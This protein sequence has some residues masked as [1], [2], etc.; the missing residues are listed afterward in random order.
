MSGLQYQSARSKLSAERESAENVRSVFIMPRMILAAFAIFVLSAMVAS[1]SVQAQTGRPVS[2]V[3]AATDKPIAISYVNEEGKTIGR[4]AGVGE[5]IYL[6]DEIVTPAGA[7]MQVL[8]RDQTVF[9]IGPDSRLVFDEFIFDPS[10]VD[11]VAMTATVKKGTF[12]FI[13]GKISKLK[14]GAMT[15]KLPNA[16]ASVRGTSVVGRVADDGASDIVLLTGAVQLATSAGAPPV[17]LIQPGWGVSI[18]DTGA[19]SEPEPFPVEEINEIIQQVE[20]AEDDEAQGTEEAAGDE[21]ASDEADGQEAE[22]QEADGQEAEGQ[23]AGADEV[24]EEETVEAIVTAVNEAGEDVSAEEIVSIIE[25]ADGNAEAVAEAIVKVIIENQIER[26]EVAPELLA[27]LEG[28]DPEAFFSGEIDPETF[29]VEALGLEELNVADI[30]IEDLGIEG[31]AFA[32]GANFVEAFSQ[33]LETDGVVLPQFDETDF[34]FDEVAFGFDS[35]QFEEVIFEQASFDTKELD[36]TRS[37]DIKEVSNIILGNQFDQPDAP[38]LELSFFDILY[39]AEVINDEFSRRE[40]A[41]GDFGTNGAFDDGKSDGGFESEVRFEAEEGSLAEGGIDEKPD[42]PVNVPVFAISRNPESGLAEVVVRQPFGDSQGGFDDTQEVAPEIEEGGF[43]T[44]S[45]D[46][47]DFERTEVVF[48]QLFDE[49][50]SDPYS[51]APEIETNFGDVD[52]KEVSADLFAEFIERVQLEYS[53]GSL[54]PLEYYKAGKSG[55]VWLTY[56]SD[57]TLG[58]PANIDRLISE[59]YAGTANFSDEVAIANALTGFKALSSYDVTLDY[60]SRAVTGQFVLSNMSLDGTN[61]VSPDGTSSYTQDLAQTLSSS[62]AKLANTNQSGAVIGGVDENG[63]GALD[64][65]ETI[66]GVRLATVNFD[67]S[68]TASEV[69]SQ[70]RTS[71]DMSVGS[72]SVFSAALDGTLGEFTISAE[73]YSCNDPCTT[74]TKTGGVGS[75]TSIVASQ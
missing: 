4:I 64:V 15:L 19:A 63:N 71:I 23:E 12:K 13:S 20:F 27:N 36:F 60:N 67:D 35:A 75:E 59:S 1:L 39:N 61:Y 58:N 68:A 46:K 47:P 51:E 70:I 42:V 49:Q 34:V 43:G 16:T 26:G 22:G 17:D 44:E 66:E 55:A 48:A 56:Q 25:E 33:R 3:I 54:D 69:T 72:T 6:N 65:G 31:L 45:F 14:P 50:K 40:V 52:E 5:P 29:D 53:E 30:K 21:G 37:Y 74:F 32:E 73:E 9:S 7:S 57:G 41:F 8:L 2:G 28:V 62:N 24:I 10:S 18:A 38:E 11:D